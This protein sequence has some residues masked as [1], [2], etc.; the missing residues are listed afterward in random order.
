MRHPQ[1]EKEN[2]FIICEAWPPLTQVT[3][4]YNRKI[5]NALSLNETQILPFGRLVI[6][7]LQVIPRYSKRK[8]P[9]WEIVGIF[10]VQF[11]IKI[12]IYYLSHDGDVKLFKFDKPALMMI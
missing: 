1:T 4:A 10:I 5:E 11:A 12:C 3:D 7:L 6:I 8:R 2:P 9:N